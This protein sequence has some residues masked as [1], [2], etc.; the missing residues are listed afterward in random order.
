MTTAIVATSAQG[1][2]LT[3]VKAVPICK[4]VKRA[5]TA[6][7]HSWKRVLSKTKTSGATPMTTPPSWPTG[8]AGGYTPA[9]LSR[10]Y[11]YIPTGTGGSGKT[12]AIV[13]AYNDPNILADLNTFDSQY[14]FPAETSATFQVLNQNGLAAPL[15]A[16]DATGWAVEESLD[17][18]SARAV[19]RLC[20]IILVEANDNG[21]DNLGPGVNAAATLGA[22]VISNSYGGPETPGVAPSASFLA[23]YDHKGIPIVV[24][25]GDHG[26]YDW[27]HVNLGNPS[28]NT[29][30]LPSALNTVVAVGGTQLRLN[31]NGTR[32]DETVWNENGPNDS[33][34]FQLGQEMGASGGGCSTV[35]IGQGWQRYVSGYPTTT[36]GT[37][38]LAGDIAALAD[39]YFG[40]D[41][42]DTWNGF[43]GWATLGGT[44]L[45]APVIAAMWALAGGGGGMPYPSISLYGHY[46]SDVVKHTFDVITG[47]NGGCGATSPA[48]CQANLGGGVA[49]NTI[50][51]GD[52]DCAWQHLSATLAA[53]NTQCDA[54]PGYDGPSGVGTPSGLA[55]F[56]ALRPTAAVTLPG[57]ITAGVPASFSGGTSTDP[58][59]AGYILTYIW[60][61]GD[62]TAN[63]SGV[64]PS[65]TYTTAGPKTIQLIVIDVYGVYGLVNVPVTV[66]AP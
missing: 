42:V 37:K 48:S 11:G 19:C 24:S 52:L 38:R 62:G 2:G 34:G 58:F 60:V 33:S 65:H 3:Y 10:A 29:P 32:A 17:V 47:G 6:T 59:P 36:C 41:I 66:S 5:N 15:P 7:C 54:A 1:A 12:I 20:K 8:P 35:I 22:T 16:N 57:T 44:S 4:A 53:G 25:T 64:S 27:D 9:D 26:W 49:L 13:D 18:Q 46:K 43:G 31:P 63:G 28:F 45:A 56:T 51:F 14:G 23:A 40:F 50:G 39:P 55:T 30:Q 21:F 61:W